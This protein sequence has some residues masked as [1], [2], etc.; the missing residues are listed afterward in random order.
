MI[1]TQ[2]NADFQDAIKPIPVIPLFQRGKRSNDSRIPANY[3]SSLWR[4]EGISGKAVSNHEIAAIP[5]I[6]QAI[7]IVGAGFKPAPTRA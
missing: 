2:I 7:K 6:S 1:G 4:P 5:K 3:L